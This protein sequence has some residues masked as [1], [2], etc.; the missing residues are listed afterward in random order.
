LLSSVRSSAESLVRRLKKK[1]AS[2]NSDIDSLWDTT[3]SGGTT[4]RKAAGLKKGRLDWRDVILTRISDAIN[5]NF[6]FHR[7]ALAVEMASRPR[8]P[9]SSAPQVPE[10]NQ[11][12]KLGQENDFKAQDEVQATG[13]IYDQIAAIEAEARELAS[14]GSAFLLTPEPKLEPE[15]EVALDSLSSDQTAVSSRGWSIAQWVLAR[16]MAACLVSALLRDPHRSLA[17]VPRDRDP[18]PT[19]SSLTIS[20]DEPAVD[21]AS[22]ELFHFPRSPLSPPRN[23]NEAVLNLG[24]FFFEDEELGRVTDT[25][26]ERQKTKAILGFLDALRRRRNTTRVLLRWRQTIS[27]RSMDTLRGHSSSRRAQRIRTESLLKAYLLGKQLHQMKKGFGSWRCSVAHQKAL[28]ECSILKIQCAGRKF[29]ASVRVRKLRIARERLE[30]AVQDSLVNSERLSLQRAVA[31]LLWWKSRRQTLRQAALRVRCRRLSPQFGLWRKLFAQIRLS[32]AIR[33]S[34]ARRELMARRQ[35]AIRMGEYCVAIPSILEKNRTRRLFQHWRLFKTVS[36]IFRLSYRKALNTKLTRSMQRWKTA[37]S[38]SVASRERM[39]TKIQSCYRMHLSLQ[40]RMNFFVT[41]RGMV[42]LQCIVRKRIATEVV[43]LARKRHLSA[44]SLQRMIRGYT[45]R[46]QLRRKRIQDIHEAVK[47]NNYDR[48]LHYCDCFYNLTFQLDQEGNT[49]LHNAAKYASKRCIK[50]LM[51]YYHDPSVTNPEGYTPLHL[52]IMSAAPA[53]DEVFEY[54]IEVGFDEEQLTSDGKNALLLAAEYG[55]IRIA[56]QCLKE[57]QNPNQTS[58]DGSTPLQFACRHGYEP[59]VKSLLEFGADPNLPGSGGLYPLHDVTYSGSVAIAQALIAAGAS[60]EVFESLSGWTPLMM[61]CRSG[62]E[63]LVDV[64]LAQAPD[65][66]ALDYSWCNA[67]HHSAVSN[68]IRIANSLREA[69]V[70]FYALDYEGNSPLHYAAQ[71]GSVDIM[72]EFLYSG[73]PASLQNKHG[74]QPSHIAAQYN[75]VECLRL[76]SRYDQHMGRMN[77]QHQTPLGMAKFHLAR[78]SQRFLEEYFSKIDGEDVRNKDGDIWWDREIDARLGDWQ[79]VIDEANH[80]HFVNVVTGEISL[81]PPAISTATVLQIAEYAQVPMKMKVLPQDEENRLN[82]NVY[83]TEYLKT[84]HSIDDARKL[85]RAAT[86]ITKF[87]RRKLA[88]RILANK[89]LAVRRLQVLGRFVRRATDVL[90]KWKIIARTKKWIRVQALFRGYSSRCHFY[91][92]DGTYQELWYGLAKRRLARTI[93]NLWRNY[94]LQ[95]LQ[96]T[97]HVAATAPRLISEWEKVLDQAGYPLRVVGL[98]E[99][100]LY[101]G[102]KKIFFFRNIETG[103]ISFHKP[104][105]IEKKDLMEFRSRQMLI[106]RGYTPA[107]LKL[108]LKLQALW[109]GH[110]I[111]NMYVFISKATSICVHAESRFLSEPDSD[112]NLF[113]YT[114]YCHVVLH[115]Y[116]RARPLY[117]EA[118]RRM[119]FKGPDVAQILYAYAIFAFVVHDEDVEECLHLVSRARE[120]EVLHYNLIRKQQQRATEL[121]GGKESSGGYVNIEITTGKA[122]EL[123][124]VGFF[125]YMCNLQGSSEAFHNYA[126]CRFLVYSDFPGAFEAFMGA[127]KTEPMNFKLRENY[128]AMMLHFFGRNQN[129]IDEEVNRRMRILADKDLQEK[130]AR[131]ERIDLWNHKIECAYSIQVNLSP[132]STKLTLFLVSEMVSPS[133][134]SD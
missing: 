16:T 49:A 129:L 52:L 102:T 11:T 86:V 99:E 113:N 125:R 45:F 2:L 6:S 17:S 27:R 15:P 74:N 119:T 107:Q 87:A 111:R 29:L 127:F 133:S 43:A 132:L 115:D 68:S 67:A 104:K 21:P 32:Y 47:A 90:T 72:R 85:F 53:R 70:D 66:K 12:Q 19:Q 95:L 51:K 24:N 46:I 44:I 93:W 20:P 101:P 39:A 25:Y 14:I 8:P 13:S 30:K 50:L 40:H 5:S 98:Y 103:V 31:R 7:D 83:Q 36:T 26:L 112:R 10:V 55:R 94:K 3:L 80:R 81:D 114:L 109:R 82:R 71:Y 48:L 88:Y 100:Y 22:V 120:A 34:L 122:F 134:G 121:S 63:D 92:W 130:L 105:E 69:E 37:T 18:S 4:Q 131:Q 118:M 61:A 79:Q 56:N 91:Y 97:V 126:A 108:A 124:T 65:V 58:S 110:K 128:N 42:A 116:D 62:L 84:Q 123:A 96:T 117:L 23:A 54:M 9:L 64:F 60:L 33:Q 76:L 38:L 41:R 73:A 28:K 1:R 75:Q 57:G 35:K 77:Y 89:R 106:E 78:E 59:L